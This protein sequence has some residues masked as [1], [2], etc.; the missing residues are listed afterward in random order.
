M[1]NWPW[2]SIRHPLLAWYYLLLQ[3]VKNLVKTHWRWLWI[4]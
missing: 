3:S 2:Q 1:K 4:S